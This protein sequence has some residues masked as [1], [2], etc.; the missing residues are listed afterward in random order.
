MIFVDNLSALSWLVAWLLEKTH[1]HSLNLQRKG[2]S[3]FET[4]NNMQV[5]YAQS[6]SIVYG[7]VSTNI[8]L[9]FKIGI[10]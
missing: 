10:V 1:Q 4:R 5:F 3:A 9:K 2:L 7:Q 8:N 6:L